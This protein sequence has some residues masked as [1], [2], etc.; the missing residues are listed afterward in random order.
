[1][2]KKYLL[3]KRVITAFLFLMLG[4]SIQ[5]A[6]KP[7]CGETNYVNTPARGIEIRYIVLTD[8]KEKE[9]KEIEVDGKKYALYKSKEDAV[10]AVSNAWPKKDL[11]IVYVISDVEKDKE[12]FDIA[13]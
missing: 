5:S 4:V 12:I 10:D 1:M 13:D 11:T 6:A 9:K 3:N 8:V 7:N 2:N